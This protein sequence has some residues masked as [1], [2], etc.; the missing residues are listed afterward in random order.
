MMYAGFF[1]SSI[2]KN[3][4]FPPAT[5]NQSSYPNLVS[6]HFGWKYDN[7]AV[8]GNP[9]T[10]IF[11]SVYNAIHNNT[12]DIIFVQWSRP[13]WINFNPRPGVIFSPHSSSDSWTEL[14]SCI[15]VP[16]K[17][18][19]LASDVM[20]FLNHEYS[21]LIK[22]V[23]YA[24]ILDDISKNNNQ[25][26]FYINGAVQ[27]NE[28]LIT[29]NSKS[30]NLYE[31]DDYT[32]YVL[33]FDNSVDEYIIKYANELR[34]KLLTLDQTLWMNLFEMLCWSNIDVGPLGHHQGIET[35]KN[36]AEKII[37]YMESNNELH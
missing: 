36:W 19:I 28:K 6:T 21:N 3:V 34:D 32:K 2:T 1:G 15:Q 33:D 23:D 18:L 13:M 30:D 7:L 26:I 4:G 22:L 10:D 12:Y 25:K 35:N 24:N 11:H 9:N 27:W 20:R 31:L 8:G 14:S 16:I 37:K 17:K 29:F 5:R